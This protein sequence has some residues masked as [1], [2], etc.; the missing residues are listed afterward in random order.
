MNKIVLQVSSYSSYKTRDF[1]PRHPLTVI[2][3]LYW[4][5]IAMLPPIA[6]F[7]TLRGFSHTIKKKKKKKKIRLNLKAI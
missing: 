2:H 5:Y 4:A 6:S 7:S 1:Q 3:G